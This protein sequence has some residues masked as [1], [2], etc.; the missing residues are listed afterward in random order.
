M[1]ANSP[2]QKLDRLQIV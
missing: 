2:N 1:I